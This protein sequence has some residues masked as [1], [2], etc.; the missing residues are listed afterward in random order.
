LSAELDA[1][2][3]LQAR[4]ARLR[5]EDSL[6]F[7]LVDEARSGRWDVRVFSTAWR[8][9]PMTTWWLVPTTTGI[10]SGGLSR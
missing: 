8:I 4:G 5:D 1:L 9:E 10:A 3:G 6:L 2:C 7:S